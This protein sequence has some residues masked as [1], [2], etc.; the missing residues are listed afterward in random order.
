MRLLYGLLFQWPPNRLRQE[1]VKVL[2][3]NNYRLLATARPIPRGLLNLA[4]YTA[5]ACADYRAV[6]AV[7]LSF[8]YPSVDGVASELPI[9]GRGSNDHYS[10]QQT[11]K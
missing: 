8:L 9:S 2:R 4:A 3:L 1:L 10:C 7:H 11:S 6:T 5:F